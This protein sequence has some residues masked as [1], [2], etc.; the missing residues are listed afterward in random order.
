MEG[1]L[2]LAVEC[3]L[4]LSGFC[5]LSGRL[6]GVLSLGLRWVIP[7]SHCQ[8]ERVFSTIDIIASRETVGSHEET[9]NVM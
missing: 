2:E 7:F 1:V 4:H 3:A 8:L 5:L 9:E 6:F